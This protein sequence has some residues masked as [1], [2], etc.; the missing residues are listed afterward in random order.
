MVWIEYQIAAVGHRINKPNGG[1]V[2]ENDLVVRFVGQLHEHWILPR[3]GPNVTDARLVSGNNGGA[4][5][6]EFIWQRRV[7]GWR[8][9][10]RES[11]A[12]AAVRISRDALARTRVARNVRA[13]HDTCVAP[14]M[15]D[16]NGRMPEA[17]GWPG[18]C[19]RRFRSREMKAIGG[20]ARRGQRER[21]AGKNC[22]EQR[23][24][25]HRFASRWPDTATRLERSGSQKVA[26]YQAD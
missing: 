15:R 6:P 23:K 8:V 7:T 21:G 18:E 3:A 20:R 12:L 4:R 17:H 13:P 19:Q 1:H 5:R 16:P 11:L 26:P 2:H 24:S 25:L 9:H 22:R 14:N 10:I